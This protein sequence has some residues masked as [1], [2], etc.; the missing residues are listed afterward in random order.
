MWS[1]TFDRS[2][3]VINNSDH[4]RIFHSPNQYPNS[5]ND[6]GKHESPN[7]PRQSRG[8][9]GNYSDRFLGDERLSRAL[10]SEMCNE[11]V[12]DAETSNRKQPAI[13]P[14]RDM[15]AVEGNRCT[16][17]L[18]TI[19]YN[20]CHC[21]LRWDSDNQWSDRWTIDVK[22]RR[23]LLSTRG[24]SKLCSLFI[25]SVCLRAVLLETTKGCTEM[26]LNFITLRKL[27]ARKKQGHH[28][29]KTSFCLI[30]LYM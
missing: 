21:L 8:A 26:P 23:G 3:S 28:F 2:P 14:S 10:R 27:S 19:D 12:V 5:K 13:A 18:T 15:R 4:C 29:V 30:S 25:T 20:Y 6:R 17:F 11:S 1:K 24:F 9:R 7:P 22:P 16:G